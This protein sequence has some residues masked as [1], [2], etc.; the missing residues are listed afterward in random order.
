MDS[1]T[2]Y[3]KIKF[4]CGAV[5]EKRNVKYVSK[6]HKI[7][8]KFNY[9]FDIIILY[10][11]VHVH[12]CAIKVV[13][14]C[15]TSRSLEQLKTLFL[16]LLCSLVGNK[17]LAMCCSSMVPT[18]SGRLLLLYTGTCNCLHKF[19]PLMTEVK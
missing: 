12:T 13:Q 7:E 14:S 17:V 8:R 19:R 2:I 3:A 15:V 1:S 9:N 11:H 10:Y 6:T 4:F 18:Y 16:R 5:P